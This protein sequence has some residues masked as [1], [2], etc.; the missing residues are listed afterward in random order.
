MMYRIFQLF[1][2]I[3]LHLVMPLILTLILTITYGYVI[4][5]VIGEAEYILIVFFSSSIVFFISRKD[6]Y[7]N[8]LEW[9]SP[10]IILAIL[11]FL[12]CLYLHGTWFLI[13]IV[14]LSVLTIFFG[15]FYILLTMNIQ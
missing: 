12:T 9:I 10:F 1:S 11:L 13:S 3:S 14:I 4:K 7:W 2:A 8:F 5:N 15:L 6:K